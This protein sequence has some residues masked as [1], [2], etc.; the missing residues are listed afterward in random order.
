MQFAIGAAVAVAR[1]SKADSF[2]HVQAMLGE[3]VTYLESIRACIH[4]GEAEAEMTPSG[5]LRPSLGPLQTTR[6]LMSVAYPRVIEILQI[7]G[8]G[9]IM[10]APSMRDFASPIASD[11]VKF[12]GGANGMS[13]FDRTR[14]M[15]VVWDLAGDAF[16][17]R[18]VQYERYYAGDPVRTRAGTYIEY[19]WSECDALVE[20]A[21]EFARP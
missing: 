17:S 12:N 15:K 8:A 4:L 14:L 18:Q 1:A 9:G 5:V 11:I 6:L 20:R 19:D 3:C 13:G 7:I 16:G 21:M 2:L 10:M